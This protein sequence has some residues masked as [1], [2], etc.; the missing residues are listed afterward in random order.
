MKRKFKIRKGKEVN[1]SATN[2]KQ[3]CPFS[4]YFINKPYKCQKLLQINEKTYLQNHEKSL[5]IHE[6]Q[7]LWKSLKIL[8]NDLRNLCKSLIVLR[9]PQIFENHGRWKK[10][11]NLWN[12][13]RILRKSPNSLKSLRI[14]KKITRSLRILENPLKNERHPRKSLRIIR[15]N[16]NQ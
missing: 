16:R 7:N 9:K 5:K 6:K 1:Y 15:E 11:T 13:L 4:M 12:S 8:R 3:I 10:K 14:Q 2:F